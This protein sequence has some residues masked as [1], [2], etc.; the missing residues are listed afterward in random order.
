MQFS[1]RIWQI[2]LAVGVCAGLFAVFGVTG[3]IA[4]LLAVSILVLPVIQARPGRKLYTAAWVASLY[5]AL[6]LGCL[7]ATWFTAWGFLGH[8]PRINLDDPKYISPVVLIPHD[9][10]FL[11]LLGSP[12]ALFGCVVLVPACAIRI[13]QLEG[14][15]W[16][17]A[18][19]HV[20]VPLLVW[21]SCLV[22][23]QWNL[24]DFDYVN[25]WFWD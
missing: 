20:L 9:M 16:R 7:Y 14:R 19:A 6:L 3:S 22:I 24:L 5:P 13:V 2:M 25:V 15:C 10:T 18:I 21:S 11:L 23:S 12:A 1:C 4:V 8:R 17:R